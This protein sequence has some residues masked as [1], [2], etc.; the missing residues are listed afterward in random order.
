MRLVNPNFGKP[1]QWPEIWNDPLPYDV[2]CVRAS[3]A[4]ILRR[5]GYDVR[6]GAGTYLPNDSEIQNAVHAL[7]MWNRDG[8]TVQFL[9]VMGRSGSSNMK[10]LRGMS[11]GSP[12]G[13]FGVVQGAWQNGGA[14][15]WCWE[16]QGGRIVFWDGQTGE[17]VPTSTYMEKLNEGTMVFARLDDASPSDDLLNVISIDE[18]DRKEK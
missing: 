5:I 16:K 11:Q 15:I 17:K 10:T 18:P 1:A 3:N 4:L 7:S 14:H 6:A 9:A 13:A 8:K 12:E 2:N